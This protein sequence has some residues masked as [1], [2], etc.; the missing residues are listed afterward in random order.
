MEDE[1]YENDMIKGYISVDP[2]FT[3]LVRSDLKVEGLDVDISDSKEG[4]DSKKIRVGLCTL[5]F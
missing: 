4:F 5:S 2:K 1:V 3:V